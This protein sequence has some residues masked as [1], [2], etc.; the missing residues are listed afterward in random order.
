MNEEEELILV[1]E[2]VQPEPDPPDVHQ[3]LP[4][5]PPQYDQIDRLVA[6]LAPLVQTAAA[7]QQ[8]PRRKVKF[9]P[10]NPENRNVSRAWLRSA[11]LVMRG[12]QPDTSDLAVALNEAMRGDAVPWLAEVMDD[13][14][15]WE[16][17][18]RHFEQAWCPIE[19]PGS[20]LHTCITTPVTGG[21]VGKLIT[22]IVPKI[23]SA[24]RGKTTEECAILLASA[25]AGRY[26]P[27]VRRWIYKREEI[28]EVDLQKAIRASRAANASQRNQQ[29]RQQQQQ[30]PQEKTGFSAFKRKFSG[31]WGPPQKKA[32]EAEP[33]KQ[34]AQPS[35]SKQHQQEQQQS[36]Q[37][38]L[39]CN[40]CKRSNHDFRSC[41][42][43][44][45]NRQQANRKDGRTTDQSAQ[46]RRVNTCQTNPVGTLQHQGE[47]YD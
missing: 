2:E 17:F 14:L 27:E 25:I 26:D 40:R 22:E 21:D 41:Y 31:K 20:I 24:F 11:S 28:T 34:D 35:T 5:P 37:R 18:V 10:F 9:S 13:N 33:L 15:T 23:R 4:P 6:A 38:R 39:W 42:F 12:R 7:A 36:Q 32:K 30:Q 29:N 44:P 8:Q 1:E 45:A 3:I 43:N 16:V 47:T 19:T 46:E